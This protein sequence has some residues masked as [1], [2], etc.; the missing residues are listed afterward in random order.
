MCAFKIVAKACPS[1]KFWIVELVV[2]NRVSSAKGLFC[3]C[4]MEN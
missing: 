2:V 4:Q 1:V 3:K